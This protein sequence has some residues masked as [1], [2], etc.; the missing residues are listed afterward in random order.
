[1]DVEGNRH[2]VGDII[3]IGVEDGKVYRGRRAD[4]ELVLLI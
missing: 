4:G 3:A 2:F 1:M